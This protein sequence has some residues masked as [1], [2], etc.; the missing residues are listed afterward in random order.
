LAGA[1]NA[2]H[3]PQQIDDPRQFGVVK[4][5][6]QGVITEFIEKPQTFVSD[7]AIIGI[8][9]FKDGA[10]LRNELE[11]LLDNKIMDKGEYQLTDAL[12]NMKA[13]GLQFEPGKVAEWLDCGNKNATV[14][15]NSR[16]LFHMHAEGKTMVDP[17]VQTENAVIIQPSFVAAHVVIKNAVV[18]PNASIGV[19][20][21]I[22]NAVVSNCII[23][24]NSKIKNA[25]IN[26]A[27][28]GNYVE[29]TGDAKDLSLGD[30]STSL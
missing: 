1:T 19:G 14:F 8:Y 22:E 5:N 7:L 3:H 24:T 23:Q 28:L 13:K 10:N 17:S 2:E 6:D 11:Y 4:L 15:T 16:I 29:Y 27:M 20:T 9:Y 21:I 12:A 25:I 26:N 18:G 30:Y